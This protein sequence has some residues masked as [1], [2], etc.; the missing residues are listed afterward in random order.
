MQHI[1]QGNLKKGLSNRHIQLIAL[2]G[3]IGT[4]LFLGISQTIKLAGPSVILGYAI[5]GLIAFL[6]MRQLGEMIVHEPVSGSFSHFA[7][8]YWGKFAG[9]MSGW[10]YWV[11]NILVCMAELSA[12][13]LYIH[14]W[15]PDI[16]TWVSALGL[17]IFINVIN[18]LHVKLF[19]EMEF[20][21]AIIK[22]VAIIA[23]IAFGS[24]LLA[25][26]S[27][28]S[29]SSLQ[30]LWQLGGFFPNGITG[31]VM[32][33]AM[34]MF[35]FGGIELVGI[36]AAE[37]DNP[38]KTL[39]KAVNQIV[40]RVLLFYILSL[41]VILSLYPWNMMAEGGSPFVL[42]F[43]SL[44]SQTVTAVL[45]FV[46]LTAAVSV[47]NSTN[48]CTSRML[49]GLAQ[50]GNAPKFLSK[51]N[52]RG[53]PVNAIMVSAFFTLIC[54]LINYLFPEKAFNLLMMLVVAAIVINWVVI[55]YTHLK[56]K[57]AM[58]RMQVK[59]HFPSVAYPF[60]NYLCIAFMACI[61]LIMS[62]SPDMQI[63]V[64]MIPVWI[65]ILLTAYFFKRKQEDHVA[66]LEK[67]KI[68]S[69]PEA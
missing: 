64:L 30:N 45:N 63:A 66:L 26:G 48:Y 33:M 6:M 68:T 40:Y 22:V 43:D 12:V 18:L 50:Q 23:M 2:G 46:V 16:P 36:A 4:G 41:V 28:H 65:T 24:Y 17:F 62:R 47:Y 42:I 60:T 21:L 20:W 67:S 51:I 37:T 57:K 61:L 32:A 56:F 13:G 15:W 11:L 27:G 5:A 53:I 7:Y 3:S 1:E 10:N 52:P 34:I 39:P 25:S 54:V 31:L 9:F 35:A 69:L 55:S 14:Y 59:T 19:G 44:G 49:L 8:K 29:Q 38:Q 58:N